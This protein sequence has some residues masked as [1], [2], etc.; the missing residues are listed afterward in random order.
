MDKKQRTHLVTPIINALLVIDLFSQPIDHRARRPDHLL[1]L[2]VVV[3]VVAVKG[4]RLFGY[5]LVEDG[6]DP[7][8]ERAIVGIGDEQVS[9]PIET[10]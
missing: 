10:E 2:V 3:P 7:V 6:D 8:F 9:Y 4:L 1:H 5:H